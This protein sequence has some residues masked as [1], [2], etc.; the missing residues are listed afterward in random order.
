MLF[1]KKMLQGASSKTSTLK[2][3]TSTLKSRSVWHGCKPIYL[4]EFVDTWPL[5]F[6]LE[7]AA[8]YSGVN[9]LRVLTAKPG[10]GRRPSN[11]PN[12]RWVAHGCGQ[13]QWARE[14]TF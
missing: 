4:P 7:P 14:R 13:M 10:T 8:G 11:N 3:L 5:G 12:S 9:N 2:L 6:R 1:L